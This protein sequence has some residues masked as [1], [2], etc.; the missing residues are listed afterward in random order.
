MSWPWRKP[1]HEHRFTIP[2]IGGLLK[3]EHPGCMMHT[4]PS[5][6]ELE[7]ETERIK[8]RVKNLYQPTKR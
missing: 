3:C 1:K 2:A 4:D 8:Q 6:D 5:L 7:A